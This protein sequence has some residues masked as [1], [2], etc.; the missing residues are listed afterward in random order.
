MY[1]TNC[2]EQIRDDA[3]YCPACGVQMAPLETPHTT[4]ST[5]VSDT[6]P[7]ATTLTFTGYSDRTAQPLH[8]NGPES[9]TPFYIGF[10][11][12]FGACVIDMI[13]LFIA[14]NV[15]GLLIGIYLYS[16]MTVYQAGVFIESDSF[17][18]FLT[19]LTLGLIWGHYTIMESSGYQATLGK[20]ALGIIVTD[21][22]GRRL[23]IL[24]A[25]VRSFSRFLSWLFFGL[26]FL[27]IGFAEKKQGLHDMIAGAIVVKKQP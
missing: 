4:V 22:Q 25:G 1:C 10:W 2:G 15:I 16:T 14:S 8:M 19:L 23:S 5:A 27:M 26:G 17:R 6:P 3:V 12:R 21:T 9:G 20:M 13:V 18:S 24:R 11:N 7:A